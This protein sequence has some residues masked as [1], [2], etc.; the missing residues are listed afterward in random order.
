MI[1]N[2]LY[3]SITRENHIPRTVRIFKEEIYQ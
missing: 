3:D 1:H 2:I